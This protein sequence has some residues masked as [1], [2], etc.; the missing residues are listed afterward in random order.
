MLSGATLTSYVGVTGLVE[1][2]TL[3]RCLPQILLKKNRR[4]SAHRIIGLFFLLTLSVLLITRGELKALAAVYT[5]SFLLVMALFAI[6]NLLLKIK[7]SRL[8][9][10]TRAGWLTVFVALGAVA[11]A[12]YGNAKLKSEYLVVFLEYLLPTVLVVT[13]MLTRLQL[14]RLTV[15][16]IDE[17]HR[18]VR[19]EKREAI[20][21]GD[22]TAVARWDFV[23]R[24][25]RRLDEWVHQRME[26]IANQQIV[27]FTRGDNLNNLNRVMLYIADNEH[28]NRVK[29][30]TVVPPGGSP[31]P[32]LDEQLRFLDE[33]YPEIDIEFVVLEGRFTPELIGE[34]SERWRIPQSHVHRLA[35]RQLRVRD[36]RAPGSSAD[37]V[38]AHRA[39][40]SGAQAMF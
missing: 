4:G 15:F 31:P 8:P 35:G 39:G 32:H 16:F 11:L 10:P 28:T 18:L 34:L 7:R 1:R 23:R 30:V 40:R 26:Q 24:S 33:A 22:R 20:E 9:R 37:R 5:L 14:L 17:M 38:T 3:D 12:V 21:E 2:M 6:G 27:F 29:V 25:L 19:R 36:R 13:I